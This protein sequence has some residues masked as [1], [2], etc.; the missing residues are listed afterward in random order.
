MI[1][2]I[3]V[4]V[5]IIGVFVFLYTSL[6]KL[7]NASNDI[8]STTELGDPF[9]GMDSTP[10]KHIKESYQKTIDEGRSNFPS[11]EFFSESCVSHAY[12]ANTKILDAA[13]G[14]LVGLGLFGTFLGLTI[15]IATFDSSNTENIQASIQSLLGV[16]GTAFATSLLGMLGSLIFTYLDKS[17]RHKL[18]KNLHVL[19]EIID[20]KYYIDDVALITMKLSYAI[21]KNNSHLTEIIEK[22]NDNL[23][24]VIENN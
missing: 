9:L 15:G 11:S 16:M 3:I 17:V 20:D 7:K 1:I 8:L 23:V 21:E 22:N 2:T 6:V 13:S 18:Q 24:Q 12:N 5:L 19:T 14:M 10:L 4:C